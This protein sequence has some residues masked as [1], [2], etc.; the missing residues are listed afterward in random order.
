MIT[1]LALVLG[2]L[3]LAA[4]LAAVMR[5]DGRCAPPS[6]PRQLG[7]GLLTAL[8]LAALCLIF[9]AALVVALAARP[10]RH[11]VVE[12]GGTRQVGPDRT[13]FGVVFDGV[14]EQIPPSLFSEL[15]RTWA[16]MLREGTGCEPYARPDLTFERLPDRGLRVVGKVY[17]LPSTPAPPIGVD[18]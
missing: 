7:S 5:G 14:P 2:G 8:G 4:L 15:G 3:G 9:V 1:T 13:T 17:C 11:G 6:P 16:Y 12:R 10:S 18:R